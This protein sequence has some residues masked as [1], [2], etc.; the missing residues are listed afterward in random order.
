MKKARFIELGENHRRGISTT[1]TFLD[2]A[3]CE[4]EQ[5]AK[6]REVSSVLYQE[7]NALSPRQ[8]KRVL[9]EIAEMRDLLRELRDALELEGASQHATL[10]IWGRCSS[11][12]EHLVELTG[13]HLRRYGKPTPGLTDYLDPKV[14]ELLRRLDRVSSLVSDHAPEPPTHPPR[15]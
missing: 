15:T 3:L 1:L 2:E 5:W 7:R 10:A 14:E 11:L 13:S 8:R 9:S 6:G 12:R 4:F